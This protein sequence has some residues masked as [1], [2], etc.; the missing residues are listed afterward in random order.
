[1]GLDLVVLAKEKDGVEINPTDAIGARRANRDD[2]QAMEALRRIWEAGD[3][4]ATFDAFVDDVV[5]REVP[6]IVI[7]YGED[8]ESAMPAV[9]AEVQYYGFRGKA[10]EPA[11]N[12]VS[13][14]AEQNGHDMSWLYG[15]LNTQAEIESKIELLQSILD[16]YRGENAEITS[17]AEGYYQA[18]RQRDAAELEKLEQSFRNNPETAEHVFQLFSFIGA[19]DW[20]R[21][22]VDKGFAI[23]A[24]Y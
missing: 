19:I 10:I 22:W 6:P 16:G 2:A 14:F 24:D 3:R 17:I 9:R 23:V 12:C 7:L 20:F 13:A 4:A 21:F 8:F 18:W 11:G 15:E 5:S 1:M